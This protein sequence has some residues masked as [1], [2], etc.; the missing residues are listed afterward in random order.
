MSR[1]T[2][3]LATAAVLSALFLLLSLPSCSKTDRAIT[4]HYHL[5]NLAPADIVRVDTLVTPTA[6]LHFYADQPYRVVATGVGYEVR[7]LDGT[8]TRTMLISFDSTLGYKFAKTF[9]FRLLPPVDGAPPAL[10][11]S[12]RAMG[13]S[14]AVSAPVSA[15]SAFGTGNVDVDIDL[16]DAR[17]GG[18]Q[19][20]PAD[21]T[22][23]PGLGCVR[24][25][26]DVA[27]CGACGQSC[28]AGGDSCSG[29]ACRCAGGSACPG[30]QTCCG[31]L[32]CFDLANDRFHC[33]SCD[34]ACNP[35]EDCVNGSCACGTG[36]ACSGANA[37]CCQSGSTFACTN[38]SCP[39]G[40]GKS[41]S[42]PDVCCNDTC[43]DV[44]SDNGHCGS[45]AATC[46][47]PLT[48]STGAC[49]CLGVVCTDGD[50]CCDSG[51]ANLANDP[52]H[53]GSCTTRCG[54][55]ET[56]GS[57]NGSAACLC[58]GA[59]CPATSSCCGTSC[60]DTRTSFTN[61]GACG[62]SCK[63]G[64]RCVAGSC[65]CNG[66]A[67]CVG[68]EVCCSGSSGSGS[69]GCFD[70]ST[71]PQ[72]CGSCTAGPCPDTQACVLGHCITNSD[73]CQPQCQN[74]NA[75]VNG[76]CACKG[77]PDGGKA[78]A[79]G[80]TCC[81][82]GCVNLRN[83]PNNCNSCGNACKPDPL[84]CDGTCKPISTDNCGACGNECDTK[85]CCGPCILGGSTYQCKD[86][87]G[88]C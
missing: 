75:C 55:N 13:A 66:A 72:H 1:V 81:D 4:I 53:C 85:S 6:G 49:A 26:N 45:C 70:V 35:G 78:C 41:C 61:C 7:D 47:T 67:G 74:G 80:L 12:A 3:V 38:G 60:V 88:L 79:V 54:A 86:S 59:A 42:F 52:A 56:C 50:A 87:C 18:A 24:L 83:D 19:S 29:G 39:C 28:G 58:N 33:G 14:D 82:S 22:C 9:S 31:G 84:C 23:C 16:S 71:G 5:V 40:T 51:C 44:R 57:V 36:T 48:C 64:E 15:N 11:L 77:N 27:S 10:A 68:N 46:K 34:H 62:H 65:T 17:C 21:Q 43:V 76:Q 69:G 30:T 37:L 8:G 32:G 73:G 20:C 63:Q 2:A 25:G